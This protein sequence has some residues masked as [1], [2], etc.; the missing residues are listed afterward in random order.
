MSEILFSEK[1]TGPL[2]IAEK[3]FMHFANFWPIVSVGIV[4]FAGGG[5][6]GV[7]GTG[8]GVGATGGIVGKIFCS[9]VDPA[10]GT[11]GVGGVLAGPAGTSWTPG[12]IGAPGVI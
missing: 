12:A 10:G 9:V 2:S 7:V 6:G 3:P 5:E 8:V 11:G 1:S 4:V